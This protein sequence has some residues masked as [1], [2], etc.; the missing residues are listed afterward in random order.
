MGANNSFREWSC[1]VIITI[2]AV[3]WRPRDPIPWFQWHRWICFRCL[4]ETTK[5]LQKCP[6]RILWSHWNWGIWSRGLIETAESE[7]CKQLSKFSQ[8]IR[9]HMRNAFIQWIRAIG[10]CLMKK[11]RVEN[12]VTLSL[13]CRCYI[14]YS[15][16][17]YL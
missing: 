15:I 10:D 14:L 5:L 9:S 1:R 7:L 2:F 13:K 8:R 17:L 16:V 12:L 3:S 11:P 4:I 6:H